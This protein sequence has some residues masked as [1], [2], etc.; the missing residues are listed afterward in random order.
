MDQAQSNRVIA[1]WLLVLSAMVFAMVV[2]GGFTRLTHSGLSMVEWRPLTGWLPPLDQAAWERIYDMYRQTPEYRA[3]NQH[4]TLDGFKSI[5]WLEFVHRLWG[6]LMGVV[7]AVP[8]VVFIFKGWVDRRLGLR[9]AVVFILG[10]LQ[11]VLGWYMVKS[12]L[13]DRPDVSQYRLTA[14]LSAALLIFGYM[15][16]VAMGLLDTGA[17]QARSALAPLAVGIGGVIFLTILSGGFV[18]GLDAGFVYNTFPLMDGALLPD[19]FFVLRPFYLNFF[20][21]IPSVQF[22]HRWLAISV[23]AVVIVFWFKARRLA[24][25]Q[26]RAVNVMAGLAALQVGLGISTLVLVVPVP[27]AV[28]HQAVAVLLLGAALW[29]AHELGAFEKDNGNTDITLG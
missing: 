17:R 4:L 21:H 29:T 8:F 12:G 24:G 6:R 20:E 10:G 9:L 18:A 5:F 2:L 15:L 26:R 1:I 13:T 27:L 7:F 19:D 14:H 22:N 25:R 28:A 3:F 11:G 16:W 23:L